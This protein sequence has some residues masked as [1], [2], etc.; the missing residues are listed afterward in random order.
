MKKKNKKNGFAMVEVLIAAVTVISIFTLLYNSIYPIVGISKASE[1]YDDIDSKYIAFYIKEML[2]TDEINI[3]YT[4]SSTNNTSGAPMIY[5]T[6]RYYN[7]PNGEMVNKNYDIYSVLGDE[8]YLFGNDI[9]ELLRENSNQKNNRFFCQKYVTGANIT[10]IY[11][12]SYNV[13]K[14][15]NYVKNNNSFSRSFKNY[16]NYMPT[17][18]QNASKSSY[19]SGYYRIIVEI[20]HE[21]Y[22]TAGE[23]Y[24]TYATIEVKDQ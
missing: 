17:Y 13:T 3:K 12:T 20:R 5:K 14:F 2:E 11:V 23:I 18:S 15:K 8:H 1:N 6:Y 16:V 19:N 22:N 7:G 4:F 21:S 9:C 24:Y 10:A